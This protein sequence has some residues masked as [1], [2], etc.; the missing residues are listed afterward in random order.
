MAGELSGRRRASDHRLGKCLECCREF[1]AALPDRQSG[2]YL[3]DSSVSLTVPAFPD[4]GQIGFLVVGHGT[5]SL[6]GQKQFRAVFSQYADILTGCPT[7]L[8]FLELAEPN[9]ETAVTRLAAKGVQRIVTVPVL[10]FSAGHAQ[11]DIPQEV[12]RAAHS[13]GITQIAQSPPLA[14]AR[15]I[16]ELSATR[17]RQAVCRDDEGM[18][19]QR[20]CGGGFCGKTG[21][22]MVGRGS[23]SDSATAQMREF[24]EL[25][26]HLTPVKWQTTAF[27]FGQ[28]P[29]VEEALDELE[30]FSGELAVVQPHLLFEGQLMQD[31]REQVATRRSRN[32]EKK[33]L[34]TDSLGVDRSLAEALVQLSLETLGES[35]LL[36]RGS[37]VVEPHGS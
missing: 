2:A 21:L 33:W 7:E 16:L 31:L 18:R 13:A 5:R 4:S 28:S 27:V 1:N 8:C 34:M 26:C 37:V 23:Q 3:V 20:V 6:A 11:S 22:V 36:N 19:C 17:F 24:V 12:A 14:C 30:R 15:P 35:K 10:L 9:I 32:P 25:R 29:T